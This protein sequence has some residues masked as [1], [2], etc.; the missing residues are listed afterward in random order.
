MDFL[1]SLI[2]GLASALSAGGG[3]VGIGLWVGGWIRRSG[4]NHKAGEILALLQNLGCV[5]EPDVR[6]LVED[7]FARTNAPRQLQEEAIAVLV[8]LT[9][10]ARFLTSQGRPRSSYLRCE[11]LI[12]QLLTNLQPVCKAGE[13]VGPNWRLERYLGCG[14]FGEVWLARNP[15]YPSPRAYKMF[16]HEG[17]PEW[18]RRE[19]ANLFQIKN[20]LGDHPNIVAFEDVALDGERPYLALEYVPGGSLEDWIVEDNAH[21]PTL[22]KYE[23]MQGLTRGLA[24]AHGKKIYHRDLKPANVLLTEDAP[25]EAKISDFGLSTFDQ[26]QRPT[27]QTSMAVQVG[28]PMYLPPEAQNVL[29]QRHPAQDNVFAVGVI[30]YQLL[31]ERLERS[32]YDFADQLRERGQDS[33]TI[34]LVARCLA[35]PDRRFNSAVELAEAFDSAPFPPL[36]SGLLNVEPLVREYLGGQPR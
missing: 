34:R 30:W 27:A 6:R 35:Q 24:V 13:A 5:A 17:A 1:S 3:L 12:D 32:P 4:L 28:T 15:Y 7:A 31:V 20:Q 14:A 36:P 9:R 26:E 21:R 2:N 10:G 33:H 29:A 25:A 16:V 8:N 22:N 23:L 19:Q 11:R 18:L